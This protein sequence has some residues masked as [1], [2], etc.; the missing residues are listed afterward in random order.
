ME[1][2]RGHYNNITNVLFHPREDVMLSTSEDRSI[3]VWDMTKRAPLYTYKKDHD[4]FWIT[5]AHPKLNLF[6]AGHDSGL[7][8]FKLQRERPPYTLFRPNL[9]LYIRD[10]TLLHSSNM[11]RML[12]LETKEEVPLFTVR[13]TSSSGLAPRHILSHPQSGFIIVFFSGESGNRYEV[14]TVPKVL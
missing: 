13:K 7:I 6:A 4:R 12:D 9:L 14:F 1:S 11:L 2:M 5:A 3:R 8:V 10:N